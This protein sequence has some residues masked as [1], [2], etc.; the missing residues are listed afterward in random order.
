MIDKFLIDVNNVQGLDDLP[1]DVTGLTAA[2]LKAVFDKAPGDL[3]TYINSLIDTLNSIT[4]GQSGS[5]NIGS[6]PI[7]GI[8]GTTVY[9][10]IANMLAVAQQAQA[11]T[12]LPGVVTD[13]M[14][15]G[16]ADQIKARF[17]LHLTDYAYQ[18]AGGTATA[19]ILTGVVL[20]DGHP[21][22]FIAGFTDSNTVK[23]INGKPFYKPGTTTSPS[24]VAGKAYTVWYNL[25]GDCFFIKA[26]AEG[27]AVA[28][29]VLADKKFSN[30]NDTGIV[31]TMPN[32]VGSG[33]VIT[34]TGADQAIPQGYYGG[35]LT[36]GK[37]AAVTLQA[38]DNIFYYIPTVFTNNGLTWSSFTLLGYTAPYARIKCLYGGIVRVKFSL[39]DSVTTTPV[40]AQIFVNGVARGQDRSNSSTSYI[41]YSED[42]AINANDEIEIYGNNGGSSNIISVKDF[43]LCNSFALVGVQPT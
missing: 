19:I 15:N 6:A 43:T 13:I 23:T 33:T 17:A 4:A 27:D 32:K 5:E 31:G 21:K 8:D 1:N 10:Q 11:G 7:S 9:D 16:G 40:H 30:D 20:E 12:I 2:Q 28:E 39:K 41:T 3:K 38:G 36:D 34:P 29:N 42:I 26:S 18:L 14:L 22:T 24:T 25:A 35:A 37:V